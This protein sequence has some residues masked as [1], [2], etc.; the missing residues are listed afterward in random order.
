MPRHTML[1]AS[2]VMNLEVEMSNC[3]SRQA[4]SVNPT[5]IEATHNL[6]NI[7]HSL[8]RHDQA[9]DAFDKV[10][11]L[12]NSFEPSLRKRGDGSS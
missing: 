11:A 1:S 9:L 12:D 3:I 10:L 2:C 4:I 6:G 8:K 5:S 7:L